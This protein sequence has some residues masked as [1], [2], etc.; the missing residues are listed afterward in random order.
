MT[1]NPTDT[2][3]GAGPIP[4]P[5]LPEG[6]ATW[7]PRIPRRAGNLDAAPASTSNLTGEMPVQ[8][9]LHQI[10]QRIRARTAAAVIETGR[11]LLAVKARLDHGDFTAWVTTE[12][13]IT[14]RSAQ[15]YMSAA[16]WTED[17]NDTVSLLPP[18]VIYLLASKSTPAGIKDRVVA[19]VEAGKPVDVRAV[20]AE[21]KDAR[22]AA[23][24]AE[25]LENKR[26][27]LS[28]AWQARQA[29]EEKR[30]LADI[31]ARHADIAARADAVIAILQKLNAADLVELV[32]LT[33][34]SFDHST[35]SRV[36]SEVNS[37]LRERG[38]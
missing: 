14:L 6:G 33:G 18:T 26:K 7:R 24:D 3:E 9:D 31:A 38:A 17:K 5:D 37:K 15:R 29:R 32:R 19:D 25:R 21:V 30:R 8:L 2:K 22:A 12:C 36:W 13:G 16:E 11:D 23:R 35:P 34:G 20:E 1:R 4:A 10:A 28:P 27:K